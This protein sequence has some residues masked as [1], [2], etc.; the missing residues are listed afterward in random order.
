MRRVLPL[1][2]VFA[3]GALIGHF[4]HPREHVRGS[5]PVAPERPERISFYEGSNVPMFVS[6]EQVADNTQPVKLGQPGE[7][8]VVLWFRAP[9]G[10][11]RH[12]LYRGHKSTRPTAKQ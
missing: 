10:A 5:E 12:T 9:D 6:V 4:V 8:S 3:V 7:W 11:L 2:C 1:V